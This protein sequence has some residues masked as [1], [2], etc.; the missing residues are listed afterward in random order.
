M[1]AFPKLVLIAA[2]WAVLLVLGVMHFWGNMLSF[3]WVW[4]EKGRVRAPSGA[5][6]VVT[7]E[8]NRGAMSSFAYVSFLL[9]PGGKADP[10]VCG[11]YDPVLSTSHTAPK[12]RWETNG[13]LIISCDGGYVT[14]VRPYSRDF[15]VAIEITGAQ[16]PP[17]VPG[18]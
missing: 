17:R 1:K 16:S 2:P 12:P 8:G 15:N 13:S 11:Y 9:A 5:C 10:N 4:Q 6:E 14:H 18:Q 3:P 7:Y